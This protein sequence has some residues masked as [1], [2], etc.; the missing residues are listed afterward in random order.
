MITMACTHCFIQYGIPDEM[1]RQAT[2]QGGAFKFFCP[3]GHQQAYGEGEV[4]KE[5]RARQRAEQENAR[6]ADEVRAAKRRADEAFAQ[7]ETAKRS[8]ARHKKRSA[9][10]VCPCCTRTFTN[11]ARHMKSQHPTFNVVPLKAVK[12]A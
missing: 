7:A 12:A 2:R 3:A 6:L 10:G 1:H 4:E 8:L 11:M 5:R 9:A